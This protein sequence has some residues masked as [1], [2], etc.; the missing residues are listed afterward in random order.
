[1]IFV[2]PIWALVVLALDV[3]IIWA[4]LANPEE[5]DTT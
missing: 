2:A 1:M 3:A 5:W 4:L